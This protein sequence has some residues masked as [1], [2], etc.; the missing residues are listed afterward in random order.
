[1]S[2]TEGREDPIHANEGGRSCQRAR[3]G[4]DARSQRFRLQ[5]HGELF[6]VAAGPPRAGP[7]TSGTPPRRFACN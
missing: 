7:I 5:C 1:V 3:S 4:A 2:L 6:W